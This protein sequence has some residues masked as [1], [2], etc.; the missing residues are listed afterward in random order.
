M[1][2]QAHLVGFLTW[3]NIIKSIKSH[4]IV[5]LC[6]YVSKAKLC[7]PEIYINLRPYQHITSFAS[8]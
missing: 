6:I 8:V 7:E 3:E 2:F 5:F 1:C 4:S